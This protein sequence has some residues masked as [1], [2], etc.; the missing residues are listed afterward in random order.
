MEKDTRS[1]PYVKSSTSNKVG[2]IEFF[3][4]SH[5]ALPADLIQ[6]IV[7]QIHEMGMNKSVNVIILRSGGDRTFCAGA[8]FDELMA[9]ENER[10]GFNFFMG[11]ANIINAIRTCPKLVIGR[12]QGKAVGGAVGIASAV[13]YCFATKFAAIRLSEI[14]IGI[15]PFVIGPAVERAVGCST[16]RHMTLNP[17][18]FFSP[19]WAMEKGVFDEVYDSIEEMDKAISSFALNLATKSPESL[20]EVKTMFWQNTG[21]WEDLM[22]E[23]ASVSG[24]LVLSE[25]TKQKLSK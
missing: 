12:I 6:D 21:H 25:Y 19:E 15:G 8:N 18:T 2:T 7:C 20:Q 10:E 16:F 22:R 3:H 11:F 13:D 9:I 1:T 17:D 5:N 4:P 24:R 14:N 23:R